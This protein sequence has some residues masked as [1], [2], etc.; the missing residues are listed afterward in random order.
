MLGASIPEFTREDPW[1][2][3][4]I[5]AEFVDSFESMSKI[6][7]AVTVFGSART[8]RSDPMYRKAVQTARLLVESGFAVITGGGPGIM[9]AANKGANEAG[10]VSVGLNI[11]LPTEQKPNRY[12]NHPLDFHYFFTRKVCFVKYA[13]A[14]VLF[15]GGF[16]TLD[17][18][19]EAITL[20]QTQRIERFPVIMI[21]RDYWRGMF[22]WMRQTIL[23]SKC[24]SPEDLDIF[25][26][27]DEPK[28]AVDHIR[29]WRAQ[30]EAEERKKIT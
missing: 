24:I 5:M 27:V 17:E 26:C 7:P 14:F 12:I 13:S 22:D 21:G 10:G 3:F 19:F 16:G 28:E 9:E 8:R 15:P 1:R 29:H 20:I 30:R 23:K 18:Y 4:R 2:I 25:I 11:L 6:G